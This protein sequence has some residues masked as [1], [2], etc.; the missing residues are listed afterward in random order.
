[1]KRTEIGII[2]F[3]PTKSLTPIHKNNIKAVAKTAE[4]HR[5]AS[6][7]LDRRIIPSDVRN[8]EKKMIL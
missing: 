4:T 7:T 5:K 2:F 1:M 3:K 8:N 6:F